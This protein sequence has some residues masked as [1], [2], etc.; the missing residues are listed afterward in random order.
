MLGCGT[1]QMLEEGKTE[2]GCAAQSG[3]A[4]QI[5]S[6]PKKS[7]LAG[8]RFYCLQLQETCVRGWVGGMRFLTSHIRE[9]WA[10]I[11]CN[12]LRGK[13]DTD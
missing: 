2:A 5:A 10:N 11:D 7:H 8:S 3:A 6:P 12:S 4:S 9:P 13:L 1:D